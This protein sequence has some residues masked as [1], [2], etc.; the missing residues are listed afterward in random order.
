[1]PD[2]LPG[3]NRQL[4]EVEG[5]FRRLRL[6]PESANLAEKYRPLLNDQASKTKLASSSLDSRTEAKILLLHNLLKA[7]QIEL[8]GAERVEEAE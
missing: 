3:V 1:M 6:D 2:N 7:R 8:G 4:T 5:D